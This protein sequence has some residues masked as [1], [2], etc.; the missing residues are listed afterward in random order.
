MGGP[1]NVVYLNDCTKLCSNCLPYS[2]LRGP[3]GGTGSGLGER[4][5]VCLMPR[6]ATLSF[7]RCRAESDEMFGKVRAM[8]DVLLGVEVLALDTDSRA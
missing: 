2:L 6:P 4:G 8:Q 1:Q 5:S 7:S 3:E